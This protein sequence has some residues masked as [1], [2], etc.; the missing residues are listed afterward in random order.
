MNEAKISDTE[1]YLIFSYKDS[2]QLLKLSTTK[3]FHWSIKVH[4]QKT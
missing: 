1:F 2:K 4:I 3:I